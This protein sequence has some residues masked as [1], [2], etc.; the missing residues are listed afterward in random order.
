MIDRSLCPLCLEWFPPLPRQ[1]DYISEYILPTKSKRASG[2][3]S[4]WETRFL[5]YT[6]L[7][8]VY[9]G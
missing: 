3:L 6:E 5:A 8:R 9:R 7:Q 1:Q 2:F 4:C